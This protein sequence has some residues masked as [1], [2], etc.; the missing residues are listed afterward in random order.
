VRKGK[1]VLF[2]LLLSGLPLCCQTETGKGPSAPSGDLYGGATF[3]GSNPASNTSAGFG[4]GVDFRAYKWLEAQ[5][6]ISGFFA[7]SGVANLTS[8]VD[9][10][11]GPRISNPHSVSRLKPFADFLIGGQ[12]FH[13]GSTQHSY[14]Y[15]NGS[16]LAYAVDGGADIRLTRH[17]AV[18]GQAGFISSRYA[19]SPTTTTTYR[20]RAGTFLVFRF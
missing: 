12:T 13:N 1:S 10:L 20:W 6:D 7:T 9:Y 14:Y 17:L 15:S 11:V 2:F 8:T 4:G 16:G 19:T 18:R 5:V 3:T